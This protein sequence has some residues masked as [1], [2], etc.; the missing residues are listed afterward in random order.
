MNIFAFLDEF[1][2]PHLSS[3]SALHKATILKPSNWL[4]QSGVWLVRLNLVRI[5]ARITTSWGH[6]WLPS[7]ARG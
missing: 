6:S 1:R 3:M 7:F 4:K 2:T 5:S